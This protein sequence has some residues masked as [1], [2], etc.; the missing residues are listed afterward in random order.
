MKRNELRKR[1]K[2][3]G[4]AVLPVVHVRDASQAEDNVR[5]VLSSGAPGVF[6]INHDFAAED[7]LPIIRHVRERFPALWLGVNFLGLTGRDAFPML[8][9]LRREG[10]TVD[11]YWADDACID[12][13]TA[14]VQVAAEAVRSALRDSGWP[15]LYFGGTAFKKQ[16]P[17][18]PG[19]HETAA[20]LATDFMDVVTTSGI[21]TGEAAEVEKIQAFRRACGDHCLAVAS[22]VTPENVRDYAG[23]VDAILVA[24]GIS[25]A[26]DFYQLDRAKLRALLDNAR[27]VGP[28]VSVDCVDEPPGWYLRLIAPNMKGE[29]FAWCDP[30][31]IYI[32]A[33]AFEALVDDLVAPFDTGDVDLV[34]GFDAMGFVL[35]AAIAA[36]LGRGFITLRKSGRLPVEV[37]AVEFVNYS[38]RTQTMELR[39]PAFAPGTRVLLVDQWVETGGTM[40][41]GIRLVERQGGEVAGIAVVCIEENPGTAY[42]RE[43]YPCSTAVRPGTDLQAQCNR[44]R[45]DHFNDYEPGRH[46]G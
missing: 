18:D 43:R 31:P 23:E 5:L 7:L 32:D 17:V 20:G 12:E 36:R 14:D 4:P 8:G 27:A 34:A 22:G 2:T 10:V 45:L 44:K 26:G 19:A 3:P 6:L 15:G 38:G 13:R 28:S 33:R 29:R 16:R 30:S 41:A 37:D 42:L 21:A 39:R 9:A 25:R 1:F 11:A 46:L 24:T 40:G 35:G